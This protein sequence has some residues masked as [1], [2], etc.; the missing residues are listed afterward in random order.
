MA[1]ETSVEGE[2]G[3][4]TVEGEIISIRATTT[5]IEGET[6]TTIRGDG[7]DLRRGATLRDLALAELKRTLYQTSF[8]NLF[9]VV[10]CSFFLYRFLDRFLCVGNGRWIR[11]AQQRRSER[12]SKSLTLLLRPRKRNESTPS[13]RRS[14]VAVECSSTP[15]EQARTA[16]G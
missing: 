15:K 4:T 5:T 11:F 10:A 13:S 1:E 16:P 12:V 14:L 2:E 8:V 7:R 6:T 3:E 9:Q